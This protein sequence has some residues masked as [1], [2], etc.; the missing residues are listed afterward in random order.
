MVDMLRGDHVKA[1]APLERGLVIGRLSDIPLLFPAVAAPLG[2][3]YALA[4]RHAEAI[5]LL[6]ESRRADGTME[7]AANHALRLAWLGRA[8]ASRESGY[9][10]ATRPESARDGEATRER[11]HEAMPC[12]CSETSPSLAGPDLE[13]ATEYYRAGLTSP[14]RSGCG[15]GQRAVYVLPSPR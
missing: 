3:A 11:G 10:T 12:S 4:G 14:R 7:L 1:T 9:R 2:L 15:A 6:E 13:M 5:R 8:H